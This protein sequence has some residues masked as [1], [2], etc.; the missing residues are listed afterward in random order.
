[1]RGAGVASR[2][3]AAVVDGAVRI[4]QVLAQ[5]ERVVELVLELVAHRVLLG[6]VLVEAGLAD[7]E[8]LR[9]LAGR[10]LDLGAA[11]REE[12]DHRARIILLEIGQ[13]GEAG[14]GRRAI[15]QRGRD[16]V[17][18]V[19]DVVHGGIAIARQG[20]EAVEPLAV[21]VDRTREVGLDLLAV[22]VAETHAD[23]ARG[24][25]LRA[26]RHEIDHAAHRAL[27]VQHA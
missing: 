12:A 7:E 8:A 27:P 9:D 1:M 11:P 20:H 25:G 19:L 3:D 6:R 17:A 21:G 13:Q 5:R 18:V 26:L 14:V 23:F 15:G 24:L 4:A 10:V 2:V 16:V 22:E